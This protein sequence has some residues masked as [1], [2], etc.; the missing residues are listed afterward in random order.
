MSRF[1]H[2]TGSRHRVRSVSDRSRRRPR[3][4]DRGIASD[5]HFIAHNVK[6]AH[7]SSPLTTTHHSGERGVAGMIVV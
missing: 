2:L 5:E 7:H 3:V 1:K 4:I 6:A